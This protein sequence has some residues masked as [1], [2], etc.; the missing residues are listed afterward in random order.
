MAEQIH[1]PADL[2]NSHEHLT[3]ANADR[4]IYAYIWVESD[5]YLRHVAFLIHCVE[6]FAVLFLYRGH[7]V[8]LKVVNHSLTI[9][10]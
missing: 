7:I 5:I 9:N 2:R 10:S 8:R 3:V 1:I 4:M 6:R